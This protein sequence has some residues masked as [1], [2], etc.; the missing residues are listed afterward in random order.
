MIIDFHTHAHPDTGTYTDP[1]SYLRR[2][3]AGLTCSYAL[4]RTHAEP[5]SDAEHH[6]C[7]HRR[8][9]RSQTGHQPAALLRY[10][11]FLLLAGGA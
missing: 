10:V 7:P 9:C 8:A 6:P 4:C 2:H 11:S 5:C 3:T 1:H